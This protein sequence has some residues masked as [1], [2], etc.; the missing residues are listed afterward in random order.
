MDFEIDQ[1]VTVCNDEDTYQ[2]IKKELGNHLAF[3]LKNFSGKIINLYNSSV[4]LDSVRGVLLKKTWIKV[5]EHCDLLSSIIDIKNRYFSIL[6]EVVKNGDVFLYEQLSCFNISIIHVIFCAC[7]HGR[8]EI[9]N[10]I[11]FDY[12]SILDGNRPIHIATKFKQTQVVKFLIENGANLDSISEYNGFSPLHFAVVNHDCQT[13][14]ELLNNFCNINIQDSNGETAL[15]KACTLSNM[16][17]IEMLVNSKANIVIKNH[18]GVSPIDELSKKIEKEEI[19][20]FARSSRMHAI[21][22]VLLQ[23]SD[24]TCKE[25][26]VKHNIV[27]AMLF[28]LENGAQDTGLEYVTS[29]LEILNRIP[30]V[31]ISDNA[32]STFT[33]VPFGSRK[34]KHLLK[35]DKG[36]SYTKQGN[37]WKCTKNQSLNK[38][39]C[40]VTIKEIGNS[41][42][43]VKRITE[44]ICENHRNIKK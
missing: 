43:F 9:L 6:I 33:F 27:I 13:A 32:C 5:V 41:F 34:K 24:P 39:R 31:T 23:Y 28:L 16:E 26:I 4:E 22:N 38:F 1:Y 2:Q 37:L 25:F 19:F 29:L 3:K 30:D 8:V 12:D 40:S 18:R 17:M 10:R 14:L 11:K 21:L 20:T 15:F 42:H 7:E 35:D 44:D 36:N